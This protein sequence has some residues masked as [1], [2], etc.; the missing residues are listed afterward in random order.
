[1]RFIFLFAQMTQPGKQEAF[2]FG[3]N[4]AERS[5][6]SAS[7]AATP[8]ARFCL[9]GLSGDWPVCLLAGRSGG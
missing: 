7:D 5:L 2:G 1:M 9:V 4:I 6:S 8:K 3:E